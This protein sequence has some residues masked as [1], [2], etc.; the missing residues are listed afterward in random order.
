M[1]SKH[2]PAE[3]HCLSLFL[4][5]TYI[6]NVAAICP[7]QAGS[8]GA[9]AVDDGQRLTEPSFSPH[10]VQSITHCQLY[11]GSPTDAKG[12][13][14]QPLIGDGRLLL[15]VSLRKVARL[16]LSQSGTLCW[17]WM[18][19]GFPGWKPMASFDQYSKLHQHTSHRWCGAVV[20]APAQRS[21]LHKKK[22]CL[23]ALD[24]LCISVPCCLCW[25]RVLRDL[26]WAPSAS[27]LLLPWPLRQPVEPPGQGGLQGRWVSAQGTS[28]G[29]EGVSPMD[30]PDA[31]AT[32][33][34]EPRA[35][36]LALQLT[37]H[38][39]SPA[40]PGARLDPPLA[41]ALAVRIGPGLDCWQLEGTPRGGPEG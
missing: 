19:T 32:L 15:V 7:A 39:P 29:P 14:G 28:L 41:G 10:L 36:V 20:V 18:A 25:A 3:L 16:G 9:W 21:E 12:N 27:T 4:P 1:S 23:W 38:P 24:H 11:L 26:S 22:A 31:G 5:S 2:K 13:V 6:P 37:H 33:T 34:E 8:L 17:S 35:T 40:C 30:R